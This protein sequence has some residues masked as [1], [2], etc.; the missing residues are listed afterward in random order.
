METMI[1]DAQDLAVAKRGVSGFELEMGAM[2][3]AARH[4]VVANR[5]LGGIRSGNGGNAR[6]CSKPRRRHLRT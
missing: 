3:E 1:E 5:G 6:G 4:L 2:L